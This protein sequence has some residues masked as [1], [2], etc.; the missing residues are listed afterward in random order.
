MAPVVQSTEA[1]VRLWSIDVHDCIAKPLLLPFSV[2][3]VVERLSEVERCCSRHRT[4]MPQLLAAPHVPLNFCP[5]R[6]HGFKRSFGKVWSSF[7]CI[8]IFAMMM[9]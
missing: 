2:R 9:R 4:F 1:T 6:L 7:H 5:C 3:Q 8:C